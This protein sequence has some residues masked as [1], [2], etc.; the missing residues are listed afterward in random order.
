MNLRAPFALAAAAACLLAC[1]GTDRQVRLREQLDV[2]SIRKPLAETWPKALRYVSGRGYDLVGT[3]RALVGDREQGSVGKFF[4][5]GHETQALS[6]R[7]WEAETAANAQHVRYR[8]VGIGT[9][10]DS[11]RIEYYAI[12][13]SEASQG[14][15]LDAPEREFR[16]V[17][18][19]LDFIENYDSD[20]AEK[21]VAGV[22]GAKR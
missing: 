22:R 3:D 18:L 8:V 16:D 13:A 9:G 21:I 2:Y 19:E 4:S 7:R 12:N 11:C 17:Q 6:S 1:A 14:F 15:A 20:V 5:K 10:A